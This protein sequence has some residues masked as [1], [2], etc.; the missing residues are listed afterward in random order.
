MTFQTYKKGFRNLIGW[1]EAHKLT[2]LIYRITAQFPKHEQYGLISQLRRAASSTA[3]QIAEGSRMSTMA[4]KR[5]YYERAY[6]S[7]AE[8]DNFL[9]LVK[10]LEYINPSTYQ[11]LL[12][13]INQVGFL[14]H[15]LIQSCN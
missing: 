5:L 11:D 9:E 7:N 10:D 14:I 6:A 2:I 15:K 1:K 8:V 4:H 3:A 12:K 13:H